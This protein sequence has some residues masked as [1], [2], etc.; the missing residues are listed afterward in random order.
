MRG[1][2]IYDFIIVGQGIAGTVFACNLLKSNKSFFIFDSLNSK[3]NSPSRIAL[4]VY[5]PLV[6]KW[7][8][9]VSKAEIKLDALFSYCNFFEN[10]FNVKVHYKQNIHRLLESSYDVNNWNA[11][12][13][14]TK[15]N[16]FLSPNL[17]S[18]NF[19]KQTF[20]QVLYSGWLDVNLMLSTFL[21]YLRKENIIINQKIDYNRIIFKDNLFY[22][23][24]VIS[25]NIVFCEGC[26][27]SNNPFFKNVKI[28]PTKGEV[29]KIHCPNLNL[30]TV[31]HTG[32][33]TVPLND[34]IYHIGSTYDHKDLSEA[35]TKKALEKFQNKLKS[36]NSF[37]YNVIE[38]LAAHRP[39]TRDRN[40]IIGPSVK[41]KNIFILNG[42]GSRGILLAPFLSEELLQHIYSNKSI[43]ID[44]SNKRFE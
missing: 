24:N 22:Y 42:L 19:S 37:P 31:L 36:F 20:G 13:V 5:N 21:D 29:I 17:K 23:D 4:G 10:F 26:S 28:L 32:V 9:K 40:P 35:P 38:H 8:T 33:I 25:K 12:Q 7:I 15:L 2:K 3:K 18:L 44:I 1:K 11:K 16:N 41:N 34:N 39:S 27:V 30:N 6:L 14:S 43:D